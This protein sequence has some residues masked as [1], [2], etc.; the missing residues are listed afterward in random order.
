MLNVNKP[1]RHRFR[2]NVTITFLA[3]C[4]DPRWPLVFGINDELGTQVIQ[5]DRNGA[6]TSSDIPVI[7]NVP[8]TV[9]RY[10]NVYGTNCPIFGKIYNTNAEAEISGDKT[11]SGILQLTFEDGKLIGVKL[12]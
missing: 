5:T 12:C 10:V 11:R 6:M 3:D 7:E 9:T 2:K 1:L 8:E 4:N